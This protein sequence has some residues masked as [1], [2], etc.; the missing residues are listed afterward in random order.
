[1]LG[2]LCA[3]RNIFA[4]PEMHAGLHFRL[5]LSPMGET[6]LHQQLKQI[7]AAQGGRTEANLDGYWIDVQTPDLLIEIQTRNFGSLRPKLDALLS[8]HKIRLVYAV[9]QEKWL[10]KQ[11]RDGELLERRRSPRRGRIEYLF[12][13][14]VYLPAYLQHPNFS[15]EVLLIQEEEL[16]RDDGRGSWRRGGWSICDRRVLSILDRRLFE[17]PTDFLSLLPDSLSEPFSTRELA[18]CASIPQRLAYQMIYTFRQ[19]ELIVQT[20]QRGRTRLY[21][22]NSAS[23]ITDRSGG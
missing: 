23:N 12:Q 22:R 11:D 18:A 20:G 16:R 13:Q 1:M 15:L 2:L 4:G 19:L 14:L 7:Y 9:A 6:T 3:I 17:Q 5:E 21:G 10:V 8:N